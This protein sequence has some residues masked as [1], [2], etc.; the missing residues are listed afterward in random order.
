MDTQ[1]CGGLGGAKRRAR[2]PAGGR[3]APIVIYGGHRGPH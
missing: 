1:V 3:L 2:E